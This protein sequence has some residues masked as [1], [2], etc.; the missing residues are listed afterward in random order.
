[1]QNTQKIPG[2]I[3]H[4][5]YITER[6]AVH[7]TTTID[8]ALW[9][10]ELKRRVQ[11]YGY[12]YDYKARAI[13]KEMHLGPLPDWAQSLA[14]ALHK[15]KH[16]NEIPDQLIINEYEPGQG[17]AAHID[18]EP[19]FDNII[20]IISLGSTYVMDFINRLTK[21]KISQPLAPRSLLILK[22]EARY[23]WQHMIAARKSD[24]INGT[25][26]PRQRRLSLTFRNVI[27]SLKQKN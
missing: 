12:K 7:L 13:S 25:R 20:A 24:L 17:I 10:T 1:M 21:E 8:A 18:C 27:L 26:Q 14:D 19:C 23:E 4:P 6:Q 22:D 16:T 11:H 2:L 3:Y 9:L 15:N 5:D